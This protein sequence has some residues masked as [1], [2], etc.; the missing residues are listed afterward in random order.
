ML[1]GLKAK[2]SHGAKA[3]DTTMQ[4]NCLSQSSRLDSCGI[5]LA[6]ATK[7]NFKDIYSEIFNDAYRMLECTQ[8]KNT[9][10]PL[11]SLPLG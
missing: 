5:L 7:R 10:D 6:V 9:T 4:I 11:T 3:A 1:R 2:Q 8:S